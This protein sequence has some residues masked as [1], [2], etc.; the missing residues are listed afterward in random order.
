MII[1]ALLSINRKITF[2]SKK[3]V[4]DDGDGDV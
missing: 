1:Y 2:L 3:T 4:I